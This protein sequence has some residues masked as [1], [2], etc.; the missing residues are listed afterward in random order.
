VY[1]S[2]SDLSKVGEPTIADVYQKLEQILSS[3]RDN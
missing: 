2:Y 1:L 3:L